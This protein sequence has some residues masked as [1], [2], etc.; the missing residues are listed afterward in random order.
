MNVLDLFSGLG[1]FSQAFKDRGH[2]VLTV[3]ID[4]KFNPDLTMDVMD[5]DPEFLKATTP[6]LPHVILASPPCNCFSVASIGRYWDGGQPSPEA[7]ESIRLVAHT[8]KIISVLNPDFWFLEN[9]R[10]MMRKV[11]GDPGA[12]ITQCQYGM[13]YMKPTD[14]WGLFPKSFEPKSCK[15][16]APCHERAPRGTQ[17]GLQRIKTPELRA[18]IPYDLSMAICK[19]CEKEVV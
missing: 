5:I 14:L 8:I 3:D 11:L 13:P 12:T 9:P 15:N 2:N 18:K 1:G 7:K 6:H 4:P 10:G 19:A 17:A 16:G